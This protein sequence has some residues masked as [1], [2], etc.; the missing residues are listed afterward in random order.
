VPRSEVR[1]PR[2]VAANPDLG[3]ARWV[4]EEE[5]VRLLDYSAVQLFV[6]RA[7][8]VQPGFLLSQ[9]NAVAVAAICAGLDGLP[10]AIEL[11]AARSGALSPRAILMR[12]ERRLDL[13]ADGPVDLPV[14]QQTL[15]GAIGWSYDLLSVE[16]QRLFR[17]LG[18][19][20]GGFTPEAVAAV[21]ATV[22]SSEFRVPSEP[23]VDSES[24]VLDRLISLLDTSLVRQDEQP[25]GRPRF[26][27]F[28]TIREYALEQLT[29]CGELEAARRRHAA[30]CLALAE[31]AEP[32]L[33]RA[34]QQRWMDRLEREHDNLRAALSWCTTAAD[35]AETAL[36]LA[37]AVCRFWEV[38]G[39]I[40]EGR[41]WLEQALAAAGS[42]PAALRAKALNAAGNLARA[43]S[44][45]PRAVALYE[46]SLT[47]LRTLGE[48]QRLAVALNNLGVI[49]QD[50]GDYGRAA[51]L[52]GESLTIKRELGDTRG[53]AIS[54][55]N[56]GM[57]ARYQG[58][59]ELAAA[60][61]QES[62]AL[63]EELSD[64]WG[65]AMA[66]N[67]LGAAALTAGD[68]EK[69]AAWYRQSL[70]LRREIDDQAGVAWCL[71]GLAEVAVSRGQPEA[72]ARLLGAAEGLREQAG[73]R[74]DPPAR[75]DHD[76]LVTTIRTRMD[77]E[78]F[79]VLWG[80]GRVQVLDDVV[81]EALA[82][83]DRELEVLRLLAGGR[84]NKEIAAAL[85]LSIRTVE[86]H[87]ATI[88][89]KTG[90]R[91]RAE[92]VAYV[93]RL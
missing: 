56:L 32:E 63:F 60:R 77:E 8:A 84:T 93:Q 52:Y 61:H 89:R 49:A 7:R 19:F 28:E 4:L 17:W 50:Q 78:N 46:E 15:R 12:L 41:R 65:T 1:G 29:S 54:L 39:H 79:A 66:L 44:D 21:T 62:L 75:A 70:T 20:I 26:Q 45:L 31:R 91:S 43:Q 40:L 13:L 57:V 24:S 33:T 34:E 6:Q 92:L 55:N 80:A 58:D 23:V 30:W 3:T 81:L 59:H 25:E 88:Y 16:E 71:A 90:A 10:L 87:R 35:G 38:R 68:H 53:V 5:P 36:R 14:R 86:N 18:V 69:A 11:A 85:V 67:N 9:E 82:L 22:P 47:L 73:V 48:R 37:A 2:M 74:L 42:A 76:R 64:A 51:A 72:A 27:M 83:T